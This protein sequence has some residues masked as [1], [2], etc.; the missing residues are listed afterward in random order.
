MAVWTA[1]GSVAKW[2]A[3]SAGELVALSVASLDPSWAV[4]LVVST[5]A[6]S[7]AMWAASTD[8]MSVVTMVDG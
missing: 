5:A 7:A 3:C 4:L 1:H 6:E 2:G 8:V